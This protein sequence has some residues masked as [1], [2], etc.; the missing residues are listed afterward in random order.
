[1]NGLWNG[2][3]IASALAM[4]LTG[5]VDPQP[6]AQS[7]SPCVVGI[8]TPSVQ[9]A[10][11]NAAAFGVALRDL[12]VTYLTGPSIQAIPLQARL[13]SQ[14]ME[15]AKQK[16]C[17]HVVTATLTRKHGGGSAL[18]RVMGQAGSNAA[19]YIPGGGTVAS[20]VTRGVAVATAQAVA[21]FATTTKA[22]DE[23]ELE[24]RLVSPDGKVQIAPRKEKL[25]AKSDGDDL[26]T[27]LVEKAAEAI[28]GTV[29]G[30]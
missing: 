29:A 19:W 10:S 16:N 18:G 12:F 30:K 28:A 13:S 21:S 4:I 25:K 20:A 2:A 27:P 26:V 6:A 23:V 14:A 11:G 17:A 3:A 1:M 15:E 7:A 8:V 9:G 5:A 22:K 24:Y